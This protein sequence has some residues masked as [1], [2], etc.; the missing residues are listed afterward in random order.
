MTATE[1]PLAATKPTPKPAKPAATSRAAGISRTTVNFVLDGLLLV[2]LLL[3]AWTHVVIRFVFPRAADV[4]G[5]TLW[6]R[7]YDDWTAAQFNLFCAFAFAV[8]LH[9][10]LHWSWICGV[11][12]SRLSRWRG[13]TVR[14]DDGSQ[15]I[16][17]VAFLIGLLNLVG[18]AIAAAA[19]MIRAPKL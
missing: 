16:Y 12:G 13:R 10:M 7:T 1:T 5:W 8:L 4:S 19:L 14:I 6:G 18:L 2:L 3:L 9:V 15:T 17:G 11:V